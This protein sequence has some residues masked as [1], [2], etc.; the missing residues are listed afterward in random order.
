MCK[1]SR[2]RK[3]KN[4]TRTTRRRQLS[5]TLRASE[6]SSNQEKGIPH[7]K[8]S[9]LSHLQKHQRGHPR[10]PT[11]ENLFAIFIHHISLT[12]I[13]SLTFD[14]R[15]SFFSFLSSAF[16]KFTTLAFIRPFSTV[17]LLAHA[18]SLVISLVFPGRWF[19][20]SSEVL[21][22]TTSLCSSSRRVRPAP[23]VHLL[24]LTTPDPVRVLECM[25]F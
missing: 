16:S 17:I 22:D 8:F 11:P 25:S 5:H 20:C 10:V 15:C 12:S 14:P 23:C 3:R 19:F 7:T 21:D 18:T 6:S 2:K 24:E 1:K 9:H 4:T 13:N